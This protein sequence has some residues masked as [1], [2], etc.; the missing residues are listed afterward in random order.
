MYRITEDIV[1]NTL[2]HAKAS[3]LNI[4]LSQFKD[5]LSLMVEDDGIGFNLEEVKAHRKGMGLINIEAQVKRLEGTVEFDSVL[6][7]GTIV[8]INI[9]L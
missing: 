2:R 6:G 3:N 4:S 7:Q 1:T 9:P 5:R 8:N